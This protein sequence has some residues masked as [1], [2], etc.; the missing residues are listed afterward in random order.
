MFCPDE[1]CLKQNPERGRTGDSVLLF[2]FLMRRGLSVAIL[3]GLTNS[4][5]CVLP[6][7]SE[8]LPPSWYTK[9]A[10]SGPAVPLQDSFPAVFLENLVVKGEG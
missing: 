6:L 1:L 4:A 2:Y 7:Y 5:T 9:F 3:V 10:V 8:W